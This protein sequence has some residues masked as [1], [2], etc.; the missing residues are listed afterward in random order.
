MKNPVYRM[1]SWLR[2]VFIPLRTNLPRVLARFTICGRKTNDCVL[3]S[4]MLH[5]HKPKTY[6]NVTKKQKSKHF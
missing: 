1:N 2:V 4:A 3:W 5:V 6:L